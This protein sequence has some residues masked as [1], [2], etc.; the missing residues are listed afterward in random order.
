MVALAGKEVYF[1]LTIP[2]RNAIGR[3]LLLL[4]LPPPPM[5]SVNIDNVDGG[6]DI[7]SPSP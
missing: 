4:L 7:L 2:I 5:D 6:S 1:G 3:L